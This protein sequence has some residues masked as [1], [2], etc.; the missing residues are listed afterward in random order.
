MLMS[1]ARPGNQAEVLALGAEILKGQV[2]GRVVVF[3]NPAGTLYS[4]RAD[5][6]DLP[7]SAFVSWQMAQ[8]KVSPPAPTISPSP[9]P[10]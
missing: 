8:R 1:N 5:D 10:A 2:K 4:V 3:R 9:R 6:V 7:S